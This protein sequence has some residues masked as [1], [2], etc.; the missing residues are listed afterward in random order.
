MNSP[1]E[2]PGMKQNIFREISLK[3]LSSPEQL[4]QLMK[5]TSPKA[6]LAL[7][8]L[9]LLLA[10]AIVWSFIGSIPTK[11]TGHGILLNDGGVI[12]LTHIASGQ[13]IDLR[14]A[15][16][17]RVKRGDVIARIEQPELVEK[18]N[19]SIVQ[20]SELTQHG[21][22]ELPEYQAL[23]KQIEQLRGELDNRSQIISP[24]DGRI[25]E[26]NMQKGSI[27][28]SGEVLATLEI[29]SAAAR[30]EAV[31]Y[32]NAELAGKI[33]PGMEVQL[34]PTIV[35]KVEYGFMLGRVISIA[36]YP[37]TARS[38][39]QPLGNEIL[40]SLLAGQ[41]APL[42]VQVDLIPDNSTKSGYKWSSPAGPPHVIPSGTLTYGAVVIAN[43]KPINKV[44]PFFMAEEGENG[45]QES[46]DQ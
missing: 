11:I 16:G 41:D 42:K 31:L 28:A 6:W 32:V 33:R 13:V 45:V 27:V 17:N 25:L 40:V 4:D 35:N 22:T 30:L 23:Q 38:M 18:I 46:G 14:L 7:V 1:K 39:M 44:I 19:E 12:S 20:L 21:K 29:S 10:S 9:G 24:I 8:S 37:E 43:E 15:S 5:V 36:E 34:S 26:M 2:V 3:R